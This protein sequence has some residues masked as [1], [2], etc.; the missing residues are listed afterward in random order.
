MEKIGE[1]RSIVAATLDVNDEGL[2]STAVDCGV[3]GGLVVVCDD[4]CPWWWCSLYFLLGRFLQWLIE[5]QDSSDAQYHT[6]YALSLARSALESMESENSVQQADTRSLTD[7]NIYSVLSNTLPENHVRERLQIFLHSS[8]LYDAEDVLELIEGSELWLEKRC[9]SADS[10]YW[11][12]N[13]LSQAILYRKLGQETLVLQILAL[14]LEDSE[15]AE[16]YC[17]ELGR[18]DAY[19]QL[20]DMYLYPQNGKEPMLKAAVRLLHNHGESLDPLQV[21]ERLSPDMPLQ[22]ASE[23][24]LRMVRARLHHHLQGKIVHSLSRAVDVD[25]RLARLEER[26][27]FVQINDESLCDSCHARLGTK[28]FAMYPDDTIAC[29]KCFRRRGES[30]SVNGHS[31]TND[32]LIKPGW[33][34]SR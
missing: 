3:G 30:T 12:S 7:S 4:W 18:S 6:L 1:R 29:Y 13:P 15:A 22:L 27:R 28:L 32:I 25:G 20:L 26:S 16:Q 5:D 23:T 33:L 8:D 19:T 17:A 10:V 9:V 14:K 21:L 11:F 34:V 24:I 2:L 31:F